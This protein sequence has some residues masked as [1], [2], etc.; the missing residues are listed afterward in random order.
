LDSDLEV[1]DFQLASNVGS[2]H[3]CV[4]LHLSLKCSIGIPSFR[5]RD[6]WCYHKK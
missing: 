2:Y 5:K 4:Q 3:H 1:A 6:R